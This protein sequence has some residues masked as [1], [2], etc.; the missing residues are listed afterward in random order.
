MFIEGVRGLERIF[1]SEIPNGSIV[2][3]TGREG[4][5]KSGLVFS[6]ISNYLC[7]NDEHGLYLSLEQTKESHLKNMQS[8][9]LEKSE[10][11]HIFDYSDMRSEWGDE[12]LDVI[13]TIGDVI[14]FYKE[15]YGNISVF[16]LDSLNAL[17][18]ISAEAE[19][20]KNMYHLLSDLRAKTASFLIMETP[21][22]GGGEASGAH[23]PSHFL[24]DGVIELGIVEAAEG[25]KRYLQVRKMRACR[26]R[27]DK[28]Q[29]IVEEKGLRVL[30]PIY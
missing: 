5:L 20:R 10:R 30:G 28:H 15:K 25:V 2:L 3:I 26:H 24:A 4:T 9:G 7:L 19:S 27:M 22:E 21:Y 8:L 29:L 23:S 14:G 1:E 17:F 11:L 16:A 13:G 18:A 6:L 12:F